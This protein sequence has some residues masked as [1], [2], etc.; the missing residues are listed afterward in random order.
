MSG[1]RILQD[2]QC[3]CILEDEL[4]EVL[5]AIKKADAWVIDGWGSPFSDMFKTS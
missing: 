5:A 3:R 4:T 2:N 1:V